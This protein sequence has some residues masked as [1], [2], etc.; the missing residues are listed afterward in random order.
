MAARKPAAASA[1]T[2]KPPLPAAQVQKQQQLTVKHPKQQEK[3]KEKHAPAAASNSSHGGGGGGGPDWETRNTFT[4]KK[5]AVAQQ[6]ATLPAAF[7]EPRFD[8]LPH[9]LELLNSPAPDKALSQLKQWR[10]TVENTID[11]IVR[12]GHNGFNRAI[13]N[14]S[15]IL[16]LFTENAERLKATRTRLQEAKRLTQ[17]VQTH[18]QLQQQWYQSVMLKDMLRLLDSIASVSQMPE[19]VEKLISEEKFYAAV[20]TLLSACAQIERNG[21][22]QVGALRDLYEE[23]EVAR[24]TMHDRI[25]D[26]LQNHLYLRSSYSNTM[27][28]E[29]DFTKTTRTQDAAGRPTPAKRRTSSLADFPNGADLNTS[30]TEADKRNDN[31]N[32]NTIVPPWLAG[33]EL[34]DFV[35]EQK[36]STESDGARYA[37]ALIE[38]LARLGRLQDAAAVLGGQRAREE[39]RALVK[40]AAAAALTQENGGTPGSTPPSKMMA[41]KIG[42]AHRRGLGTPQTAAAAA[43]AAIANSASTQGVQRVLR[44]VFAVCATTLAHHKAV[45]QQMLARAGSPESQAAISAMYSVGQVWACVQEEC[46][47]LLCAILQASVGTAPPLSTAPAAT[48]KSQSK[49]FASF[50]LAGP[51]L[52]DSMSEA[53]LSFHFQTRTSVA[54]Q[55]S[56]SSPTGPM[57]P[58]DGTPQRGG[59]GGIADGVYAFLFEGGP[60][61]TAAVYRPFVD[62]MDGFLSLSS[63]NSNNNTNSKDS[64]AASAPRPFPILREF[65]EKFVHEAFLPRLRIDYRSRLGEVLSAQSA[66]KPHARLKSVYDESIK[67]GRPV[68]PAALHTATLVQELVKWAQSLPL[69]ANDVAALAEALHVRAYD[70]AKAAYKEATDRATSAQLA[71]RN[72]V[73]TAMAAEPAHSWIRQVSTAEDTNGSS[74]DA[75]V[76]SSAAGASDARVQDMLFAARPLRPINLMLEI[77]RVVRVA[78]IADSL[79][80]LADSVR[81]LGRHKSDQQSAVEDMPTMS[82]KLQDASANSSSNG[83]TRSDQQ[84]GSGLLTAALS[85]IGAKH[86]ALSEV[87]LRTLRLESQLQT[88]FFLQGMVA[89]QDASAYVLEEDSRDPE[90]F[91]T[92]C[93]K[94]ITRMEEEVAPYLPTLKRCYAFGAVSRIAAVALMQVPGGLKNVNENGVRQLCRNCTALQQALATVGIAGSFDGSVQRQFGHVRSYYSLLSLSASDLLDWLD[95]NPRTYSSKELT[96]LVGVNAVRREMGV[97]ERAKVMKAIQAMK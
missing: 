10:D 8:T 33:A 25:I 31:N 65:I 78:A 79:A 88:L 92:A 12:T 55:N 71:G 2:G 13:H 34:D 40:G 47:A 63:N 75:A 23:L 68:L 17:A 14:F 57:S 56:A 43:A 74:H 85:A 67:K 45:Y 95:R 1:A 90:D 20:T 80:Y 70:A 82:K 42:A 21:L 97:E 6:L 3:H 69:F 16:K 91:I 50:S 89:P 4:L 96:A 29:G 93:I 26:E 39:V 22:E 59:A 15:L 11:D 5:K 81:T 38:C 41:S 94:Q 66:F 84:H 51:P 46:K 72:D 37:R 44:A 77:S 36:R 73:E 9:V 52:K 62:Q 28:L 60:Y 18:P 35:I 54:T 87:A 53:Q 58:R 27:A 49:L 19:K 64:S 83:T 86:Q 32:A 7:K 76:G 61:L 24:S 30:S 48:L